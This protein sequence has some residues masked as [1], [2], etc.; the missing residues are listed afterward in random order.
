MVDF[1]A[2][3]TIINRYGPPPSY[4]QLKIPGLNAPIPPGAQWGFHPGGWGKPPTDQHNRPLYG[5][6]FGTMTVEVDKRFIVEP[7]LQKWGELQPESEE[8]EED[9]SDQDQN[10]QSDEDM[11][12]DQD[13]TG[14][15]TPAIPI[16]GLETPAEIELVKKYQDC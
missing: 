1:N 9:E 3:V 5:D 13:E 14:T 6:V 2:K 16:Q 8:E 10:E 4:P 15:E 12:M 11:E 7:E